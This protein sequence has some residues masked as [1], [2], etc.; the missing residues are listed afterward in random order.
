MNFPGPEGAALNVLH[1]RVS[2]GGYSSSM[3]TVEIF[4]MQ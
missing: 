3:F 1:D 4:K 2:P